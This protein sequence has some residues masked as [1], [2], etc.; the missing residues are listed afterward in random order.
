MC[1]RP[2]VFLCNVCSK[3]LKREDHGEV[4]PQGACMHDSNNM[5]IY[6]QEG[7][8]QIYAALDDIPFACWPIGSAGGPAESRFVVLFWQGIV[9]ENCCST[10][11]E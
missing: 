2:Q 3:E 4:V 6:F 1:C 5:S 9:A 7:Y 8:R 10:F 11:S